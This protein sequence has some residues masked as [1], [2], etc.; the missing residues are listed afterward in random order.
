M[1]SEAKATVNDVNQRLESAE[2]TR[3]NVVLRNRLDS[4]RLVNLGR[5]AKWVLRNSFVKEKA[6]GL[7]KRKRHRTVCRTCR[8]WWAERPVRTGGT[9]PVVVQRFEEKTGGVCGTKAEGKGRKSIQAV[10]CPRGNTRRGRWEVGGEGASVGRG[11]LK[12]IAGFTTKRRS[13]QQGM[14]GLAWVLRAK[15]DCKNLV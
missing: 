9:E 14:K 3:K 12:K 5:A 4:S 6:D 8:K 10:C 2:T 1:A 7:R 13:F 11:H 15:N